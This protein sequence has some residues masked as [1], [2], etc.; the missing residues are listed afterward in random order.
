MTNLRGLDF[1]GNKAT[2]VQRLME[3]DNRREHGY[4][5]MIKGKTQQEET[6]DLLTEND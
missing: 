4:S 2:L 5:N 6:E 3:D 1:S